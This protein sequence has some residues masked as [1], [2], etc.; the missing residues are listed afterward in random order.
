MFVTALQLFWEIFFFRARSKCRKLDKLEEIQNHM[1]QFKESLMN[2]ISSLSSTVA[3]R[4]FRVE[5]CKS[6]PHFWQ[7]PP[8]WL[9]ALKAQ[10]L[11]ISFNTLITQ[12][13]VTME[14]SIS[15]GHWCVQIFVLLKTWSPATHI[16]E[17]PE[18]NKL[19]DVPDRLFPRVG[20]QDTG[21]S[22]QELHG[23]KVSV[24]NTDDDDGHG[25][26]GGLNDGVASLVHVADDAVC[27]DEEREVLLHREGMKGIREI[28]EAFINPSKK[29]S[30]S[31]AALC[32]K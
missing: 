30:E 15:C 14:L 7:T 29:N 12:Q 4:S 6:R 31:P 27:D 20:P 1:R 32:I 22:I 2:T 18:R 9:W 11:W 23:G 25:E 13:N 26:L 17:I 3:V 19:H 5:L 8:P 28:K 10:H 24:A 16:T 21:V